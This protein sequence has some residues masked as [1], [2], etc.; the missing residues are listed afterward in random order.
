M[1]V[2]DA[3]DIKRINRNERRNYS[4]RWMRWRTGI[5][6][7]SGMSQSGCNCNY[8]CIQF[9]HEEGA[10]LCHQLIS[11]STTGFVDLGVGVI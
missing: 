3:F 7:P 4:D 9:V 11:V 5:V 10:N 1:V 8:Y 6:T 2:N